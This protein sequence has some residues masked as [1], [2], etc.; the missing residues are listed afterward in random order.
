MTGNELY[1]K[2]KP[3]KVLSGIILFM[4][5]IFTWIPINI[6]CLV[7]KHTKWEEIKH[8]ANV[9]INDILE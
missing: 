2:K 1:K 4:V 7:K 8:N 3:S 9:K 6:L 5:F